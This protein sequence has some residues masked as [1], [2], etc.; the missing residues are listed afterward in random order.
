[1]EKKKRRQIRRFFLF[2]DLTG[3]LAASVAAISTSPN[4]N[5]NPMIAAK[6]AT[7][8]TVTPQQDFRTLSSI[9]I[10]VRLILSRGP[11]LHRPPSCRGEVLTAPL[12]NRQPCFYGNASI[13]AWLN[14]S[15]DMPDS[16]GFNRYRFVARMWRKPQACRN[17]DSSMSSV[18]LRHR[19]RG[20]R[21]VQDR[22]TTT[23]RARNVRRHAR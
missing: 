17:R 1:M 12:T 8:R 14:F 4:N 23:V 2:R 19:Q 21:F 22:L 16:K 7:A 6:P 3:Q 5:A 18:P 9:K 15:R 10:P 11:G 13:S 20:D